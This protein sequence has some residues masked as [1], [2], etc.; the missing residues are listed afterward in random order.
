MAVVLDAP[1]QGGGMVIAA[2]ARVRLIPLAGPQGLSVLGQ[3]QPVA[4]L[5]H[6]GIALRAFDIAGRPLSGAEVDALLPGAAGVMDRAW[7][8]R[9]DP[10]RA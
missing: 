10:G 7:R 9:N 4:V 3:K 8:S 6:D 1:V 2:L 5:L